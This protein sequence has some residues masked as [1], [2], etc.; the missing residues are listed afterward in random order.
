[1]N[2]KI[3]LMNENEAEQVNSVYNNAYGNIRSLNY[4]EWEF[5][6]GPWGKAIY[7]VAEDIDKSENKIVGTQCAIPIVFVD[8][9]MQKTE[10]NN[11]RRP[12]TRDTINEWLQKYNPHNGSI[13][14]IS[15]Q[16]FIGYQDAVLRNILPKGFS[17]ETVGCEN[18]ENETTTIILD[19]LARWIYHEY[20]MSLSKAL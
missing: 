20:Q 12:N 13:L 5:I 7:V 1:M 10:N 11:L 16:P 2:I 6:R 9:P 18:L 17:I 15:N 14:A 8:T 3:R 4:F 19:S